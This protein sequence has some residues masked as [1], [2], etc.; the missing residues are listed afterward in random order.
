M[1]KLI[2]LGCILLLMAG[3]VLGLKVFAAH[4]VDAK[5]RSV[6]ARVKD[7]ADISFRDVE[8]SV[9]KMSLVVNDVDVL[10][11]TGQTVHIDSVVVHDM[12]VKHKPPLHAKVSLKGARLPVNEENFGSEYKEIQELGYEELLADVDVQYAYAPDRST[13][14]LQS[15]RLD[16]AGLGLIHAS[17]E[18]SN[19]DLARLRAL[20][21]DDLVVERLFFTYEDRALLRTLIQI[22]T[23][24]EREIIDF[25]VAGLREDIERAQS[26]Q[27]LGAVST[28]RAIIEFIETPV[29]IT[30]GVQLEQPTSMGQILLSKKITDIVKLFTITVTAT[31]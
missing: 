2:L 20:D 28:M 24:D 11:P 29:G 7:R 1:K 5:L 8:V 14:L 30:V 6:T 10:L 31:S 25:L 26:R 15:L 18:C 27:Q 12:D 22:T 3:A 21:M 23:V 4:Y 16:I 17:L 13:F 19:F 9:L